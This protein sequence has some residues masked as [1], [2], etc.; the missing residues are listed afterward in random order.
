MVQ[1]QFW[2]NLHNKIK[3]VQFMTKNNLLKPHLMFFTSWVLII[4]ILKLSIKLKLIYLTPVEIKYIIAGLALFYWC[5][6]MMSL[7]KIFK[8]NY[9]FSSNVSSWLLD[10]NK[11]LIN[12][13]INYFC[14]SFIWLYL[15]VYIWSHL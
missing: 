4:L 14:L 5:L 7:Y 3:K 2:F 8:K 9:M 13:L 6:S 15:A 1:F 12:Q 11:Q 10:E